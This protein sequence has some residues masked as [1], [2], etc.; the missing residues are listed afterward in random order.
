MQLILHSQLLHAG[1][2]AAKYDHCT[3]RYLKLGTIELLRMIYFA[4]RDAK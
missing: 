3:L 1:S 4:L 2:L